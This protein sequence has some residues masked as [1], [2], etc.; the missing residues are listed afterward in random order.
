M[1]KDITK[2]IV[3]CSNREELQ[4]ISLIFLS[5]GYY[6]RHKE[7]II[8][9]LFSFPYHIILSQRNLDHHHLEKNYRIATCR[10]S[11]DEYKSKEK[12]SFEQFIE[13]F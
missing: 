11:L 8:P 5:Y 2:I 4:K 7:T 10:K 3:T 13:I 12:L 9:E 1:T 6:W